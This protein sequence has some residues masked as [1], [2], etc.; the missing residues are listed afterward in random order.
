MPLLP[1]FIT[2]TAIVTILFVWF[3]T[4]AFYEYVKLF[5]IRFLIEG[6]EQVSANITYPQYL[7]INRSKITNNKALIF[8]IKLITCPLCLSF[9]LCLCGGIVLGSIAL[10]FPLYIA[11]LYVY[12]ILANILYK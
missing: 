9:W 5:G 2:L 11:V 7:F 8:V 3:K 12:G 1:F 10:M 6:F 4:D